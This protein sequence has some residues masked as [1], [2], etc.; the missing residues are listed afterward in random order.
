MSCFRLGTDSLIEPA[1]SSRLFARRAATD[2]LSALAITRQS[3]QNP[4]FVVSCA[5]ARARAGLGTVERHDIILTV[6]FLKWDEIEQGY[7]MKVIP[8]SK[9]PAAEMRPNGAGRV[10]ENVTGAA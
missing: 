7:Q 9:Q 6:L 2:R 10:S 5:V 4:P 8:G 3:H 1:P